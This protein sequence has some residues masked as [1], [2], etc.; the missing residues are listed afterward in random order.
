MQRGCIMKITEI[1]VFTVD[2][3]RLKAY[4]SIILDDCFIVRDLKIIQGNG[5]LF[6]AM[7]S[8]KRNDGTYRDIAHPLN[9]DTRTDMEEQIL[10][11][12]LEEVKGGGRGSDTEESGQDPQDGDSTQ[13]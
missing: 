13:E 5:G 11:A 10:N 1:K 8:K 9:K 4:I 6:V 7:P 2:E 12:Y 3:D